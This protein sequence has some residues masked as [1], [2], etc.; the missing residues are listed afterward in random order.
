MT[1]E[2]AMAPSLIVKTQ[3]AKGMSIQIK[4]CTTAISKA[5]GSLLQLGRHIVS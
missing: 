2:R 4:S 5:W 3:M 1:G